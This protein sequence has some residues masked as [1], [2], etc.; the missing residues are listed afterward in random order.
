M[1][2]RE[3]HEELNAGKEDRGSHGHANLHVIDGYAR[4]APSVRACIETV[5]CVT[6]PYRLWRR[7]SIAALTTGI[8]ALSAA[9]VDETPN[10]IWRSVAL[11]S[12]LQIVRPSLAGIDL[13]EEA[14]VRLVYKGVAESRG[15][16]WTSS[17]RFEV[18][19][20]ECCRR[21]L[22]AAESC[23]MVAAGVPLLGLTLLARCCFARR[24]SRS[25]R[26]L[27]RIQGCRWYLLWYV[28][29]YSCQSR[30]CA[31]VVESSPAARRSVTGLLRL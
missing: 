13:S 11:T 4:L 25:A 2:I 23:H 3:R 15:E 18:E 1:P 22:C 31:N 5:A 12:I 10:S 21:K 8:R 16:V 6:G 24:V 14:A 27:D 26:S 29:G 19:G 9:P 20:E 7:D 28:R 17:R 30:G